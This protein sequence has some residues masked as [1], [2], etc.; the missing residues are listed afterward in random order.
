[1]A[2]V[3]PCERRYPSRTKRGGDGSAASAVTA[4]DPALAEEW[5]SPEAVNPS[6]DT[7]VTMGQGTG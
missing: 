7:D 3:L 1:M 5:S 6:L 2:V 4:G